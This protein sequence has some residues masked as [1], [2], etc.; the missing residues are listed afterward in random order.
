MNLFSI[1]CGRDHQEDGRGAWGEGVQTTPA[2]SLGNCSVIAD[3]CEFD[4][5]QKKC[6]NLV[7]L[8]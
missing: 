5:Q 3:P 8:P 1:V 7:S 2:V 6:C 4:K